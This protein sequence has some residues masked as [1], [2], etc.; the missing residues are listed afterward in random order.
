MIIGG[1]LVAK[2]Q[3]IYLNDCFLAYYYAVFVFVQRLL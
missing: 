2:M 3:S 1:T